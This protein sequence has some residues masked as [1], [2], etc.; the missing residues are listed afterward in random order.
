[1]KLIAIHPILYHSTQYQPGQSLPVNNP[2]MVQAWLSAG[3]AI[4]QD[5]EI[6]KSVK[7]VPASAKAGISGLTAH[8][9]TEENL[10]GK[11]PETPARSK[12]GRK[13]G[14]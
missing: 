3:T 10:V 13:Y 1:M 8:A 2:G 4:W 5:E 11:I 7:A 6:P 9:E 12:G 14:K